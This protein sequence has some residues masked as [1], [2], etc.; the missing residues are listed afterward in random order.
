MVAA[1]AALPQR[2]TTS[3]RKIVNLPAIRQPRKRKTRDRKMPRA[4]GLI[5]FRRAYRGA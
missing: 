5:F 4:F 1:L 2:K 3:P